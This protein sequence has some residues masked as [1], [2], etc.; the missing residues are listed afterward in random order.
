MAAGVEY[1]TGAGSSHASAWRPAR[2]YTGASE[3]GEPAGHGG[4]VDWRRTSV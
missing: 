3:K 2:Y 4:A 1:Y